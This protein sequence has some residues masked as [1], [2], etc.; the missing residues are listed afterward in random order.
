MTSSLVLIEGIPGSGKTSLARSIVEALTDAER[1]TRWY[2]EEDPG[3]PVFPQAV[4]R[5]AYSASFP[6]LCLARWQAFVSRAEPDAVYVLEGVTFQSTVRFMYAADR[7]VAENEAY[8]G[9]FV[10][11][12]MPSC[13]VL[14]YL[15]QHD[16]AAY[17]SEFV[18]RVRGS[19][20]V[21]KISAYVARTPIG[22]RHQWR[23][24]EGATAF[25]TGYGELCDRLVAQ[26]PIATLELSVDELQHDLA[27][28][29]AREWILKRVLGRTR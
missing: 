12:V 10:D 8:V 13:P 2:V 3:H 20:W 26:M 1:S 24:A 15:R 25:W 22:L 23:G 29:Q 4:R 14:V 19:I 17:L 7:S 28:T 18:Y 5:E 11:V 27:F 6:D 9:R 16:R 21:G